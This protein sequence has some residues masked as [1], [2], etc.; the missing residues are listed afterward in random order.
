MKKYSKLALWLHKLMH[1]EYWPLQVVYAPV[2]VYWAYLAV[3]ARSFVFFTASNPSI[4]SGGMVGEGKYNTLKNIPAQYRTPT[5]FISMSLQQDHIF[6]LIASQSWS[7]PLIFKPDAGERGVRVERINNE[8]EAVHY[9]NAC[10]YD[11]LIQPF[12]TY[13]IELGVFYYRYP[14]QDRGTVISIVS[15]DFLSVTGD[16]KHMLCEL[17]A[18]SPRAAYQLERMQVKFKDQWNEV[19]PKDEKLLLESIG[20]HCRGTSFRDANYLIDEQLI[21]TFDNIAKQI[22]GFYFGRFDL[23]CTSIEKMKRG[24]DI[25]IM[26]LNGANAEQGHIYEPGYSYFTALGTILKQWTIL[27]EISVE[28]NKAGVPYMSFQDAIRHMKK[29]KALRAKYAA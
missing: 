9:I 11:F 4:E 12:I 26:E 20:N 16:G 10:T 18:A 22:E 25:Q 7:Y 27:Y 2:F 24:E 29:S 23:K 21:N 17:V 15:K 28:N 19:V 14:S 5:L 1:W 8:Q 13:P 6:Q 3:K